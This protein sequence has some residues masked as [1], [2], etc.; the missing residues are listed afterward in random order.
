MVLAVCLCHGLTCTMSYRCVWW[1]LSGILITLLGNSE[2][3]ALLPLVC[4]VCSVRR[5]LFDLA[6]GVIGRLFPVTAALSRYLTTGLKG[7][8]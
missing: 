5:S 2:L 6:I 1:V 4:N 7:R 3:V 8:S